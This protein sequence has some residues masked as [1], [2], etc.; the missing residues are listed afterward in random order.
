MESQRLLKKA[1]HT[2]SVLGENKMKVYY[3][4]RRTPIYLGK[5]KKQVG[6]HMHSK[7]NLCR[8]FKPTKLCI[9]IGK[10]ICV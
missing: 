5:R 10:Y 8:N 1:K 7:N 9:S 6:K 3:A 4:N 2:Q